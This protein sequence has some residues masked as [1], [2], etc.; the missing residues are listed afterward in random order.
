MTNPLTLVLLIAVSLYVIK[1]WCD[2]YRSAKSGKPNE[3]GLPG[4]VPAPTAAY[5]IACVGTLVI[6]AAETWGELSLGLADQQSNMTVLFSAYTL[7]AAFV[8]EIIFRGYLV[9]TDPRPGV[10]WGTAIGASILFA[11]L[12]PFLWDWKDNNLVLHFDAKGVFS[13]AAVF[14]TSLWF[15]IA[16]LG[17][18][19][20]AHSLA[21][22][23]AGH[24]TKNIGVIVI[25]GIQGHLAGLY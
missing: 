9:T 17:S 20:P 6:L 3:R 24:L 15:Y 21:P 5:V 25:K 2:D 23:F 19:N 8:E 12:H 16:R 14:M 1:L 18:F 4:T 13:T 7:C 11:A 22:C 10:R